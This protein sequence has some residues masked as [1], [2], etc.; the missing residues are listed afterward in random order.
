[1]W[2]QV[3]CV[4]ADRFFQELEGNIQHRRRV[5]YGEEVKEARPVVP[6]VAMGDTGF[7]RWT[8]EQLKHIPEC[9]WSIIPCAPRTFLCA[10]P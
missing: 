10:V 7:G 9:T 3:K 1:M 6:R 5:G 2:G 8:V 4:G